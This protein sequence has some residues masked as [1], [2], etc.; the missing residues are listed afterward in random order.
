MNLKGR[1]HLEAIAWAAN[2]RVQIQVGTLR[3]V[4]SADEATGFARL[5]LAAGDELRVDVAETRETG[6]T[7]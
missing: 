5:L 3:F 2:G 7:R 6:G 4:A 1:G